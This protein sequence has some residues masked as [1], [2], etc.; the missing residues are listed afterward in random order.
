M[1]YKRAAEL[2]DAGFAAYERVDVVRQGD[3]L[4]LA[5]GVENG[6]GA[7]MTP[8]AGRSFS[9]LRRRDQERDLQVRYQLPAMIAAPVKRN[10]VIGELIVEEHG[11]LVAVI[12]LVSPK[13]V[14]AGS[15]RSAARQ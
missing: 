8:V 12:P 3:R 5:V 14:A 2:I 4:D 6:V 13:N 1:R 9:V 10:Q 7:T 15:V 11:E